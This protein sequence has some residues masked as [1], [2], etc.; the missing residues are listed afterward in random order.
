MVVETGLELRFTATKVELVAVIRCYCSFIHDALFLTLSFQGAAG[1]DSA[2]TQWCGVAGVGF[3]F[4]HGLIIFGNE[5]SNAE[6]AAVAQFYVVVVVA[7]L[8]QLM[9][10]WKV[11]GQKSAEFPTDVGAN[12]LTIWWVEPYNFSFCR[13]SFVCEGNYFIF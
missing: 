9:S 1:S 8:V 3:S 11:L 4:Y 5:T 2:A 12:V 7:D 6:H 10:W 13:S